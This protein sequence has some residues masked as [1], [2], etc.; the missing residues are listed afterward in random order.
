MK[1]SMLYLLLLYSFTSCSGQKPLGTELLQQEK[2][3]EMPG[4][5]GR[6]DHL[7]INL[8]ENMLYVA[9]LGNNSIEVVDIKRGLVLHS[10]KGLDEPQGVAYIP[11][12]NE[13]VV[14]NGGNG[15]CIFYNASTYGVIATIE[16]GSDA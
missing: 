3:I 14:A 12:A 4:V 7:A 13:L 8:K 6:I 16:F 1:Q 9:A 15:N 2:I 10:I 11:V 5:N